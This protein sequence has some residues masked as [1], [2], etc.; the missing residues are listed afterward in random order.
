MRIIYLNNKSDEELIKIKKD[1]EHGSKEIKNK[2]KQINNT[3]KERE[4]LKNKDGN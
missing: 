3:L 2:I 4:Q 1:L